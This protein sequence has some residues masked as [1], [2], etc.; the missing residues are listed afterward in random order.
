MKNNFVDAARKFLLGS[1]VDLKLHMKTR[2]TQ[3]EEKMPRS[4][5]SALGPC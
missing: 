5:I 4:A 1:V 3:M 2:I